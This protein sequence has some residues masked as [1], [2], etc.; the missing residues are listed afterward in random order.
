MCAEFV[1][2][3]DQKFTHAKTRLL[4]VSR[5]HRFL[6]LIPKNQ[7]PKRKFVKF[8]RPNTHDL[9]KRGTDTDVGTPSNTILKVKV[10][11]IPRQHPWTELFQTT[12]FPVSVAGV[13]FLVDPVTCVSPGTL[14][15]SSA[16][17]CFSLT[18]SFTSQPSNAVR[19]LEVPRDTGEVIKNFYN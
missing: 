5:Y 4:Q 9:R 16:A 11:P 13:A 19:S 2:F 6:W 3:G 14:A 18:M 7:W 17:L 8:I 12:W 10:T 15:V 1:Y